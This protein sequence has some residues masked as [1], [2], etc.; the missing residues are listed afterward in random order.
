VGCGVCPGDF[1]NKTPYKFEYEGMGSGDE[2]GLTGQGHSKMK[3]TELDLLKNAEFKEAFDE[4]DKDGSG[5]ISA[6]ELLEVMRAMG[7]NPTEDEVLNMMLEADLDGNGSIEFPEFLELM[8][9]KYSS[10]DL[11]SDLREAFKIFDRDNDGYIS[12]HEFKR[13]ST[14]LGA[15]LRCDEIEEL[16]QQADLDGNGLLDYEEFVKMLTDV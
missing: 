2:A 16:M 14:L 11:E 4:F 5:A 8:K 1:L 12:I 6:E 10:D 9:N 13:V 15:N 3:D 7:Q